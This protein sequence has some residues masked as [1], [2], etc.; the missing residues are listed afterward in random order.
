MLFI[1]TFKLGNCTNPRADCEIQ[2]VGAGFIYKLRSELMFASFKIW[3]RLLD[4]ADGNVYDTIINMYT[5]DK[6]VILT[7]KRKVKLCWI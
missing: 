1:S 7:V 4:K 2:L 5:Q 3:K 6:H